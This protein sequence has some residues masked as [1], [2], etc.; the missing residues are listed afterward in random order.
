MFVDS[1]ALPDDKNEHECH[2]AKK[3]KARPMS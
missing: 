2:G 3:L 1:E